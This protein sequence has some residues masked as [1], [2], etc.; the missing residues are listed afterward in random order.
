MEVDINN[1]CK[2][3]SNSYSV[4]LIWLSRFAG[5]HPPDSP[6]EN[7]TEYRL[8]TKNRKSSPGKTTRAAFRRLSLGRRNDIL[9]P[10]N[11]IKMPAI[12]PLTN[13]S[14]VYRLDQIQMSILV[15]IFDELWPSNRSDELVC[16][17]QISCKEW[18]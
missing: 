9:S 4:V 1:L 16:K 3:W 17:N 2:T 11:C 8:N 13:S 12:Q 7:G 14:K 15:R 10:R 5:P 18:R 6:F